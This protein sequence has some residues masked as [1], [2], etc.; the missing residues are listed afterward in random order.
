MSHDLAGLVFGRLTAIDRVV[1][2][3]GYARWRC[4]CS[5]GGSKVARAQTL[6]N[7]RTRSCG[8]LSKEVAAARVTTHGDTS[9]RSTTPEY[10]SYASMKNRCRNPNHHE[11]HRYGGRGIAICERW[12]ESFGAF[13]E[14]MGRKP[15]PSFTIDRIDNDKGYEPGNCRWASRKHQNRNS[16]LSKQVLASD[17]R[18]FTSMAEAAETFGISP[19]AMARA[20]KSGR[21]VD[22][23]RWEVVAN[24][25]GVSP[26]SLVR[27]AG[28]AA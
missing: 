11:F 10:R 24:M 19:S 17:G 7:G 9:N 25:I 18:T 20:C 28:R 27:E 4:S 6:R 15:D 14:D 8:C 23:A 3:D 5:C 16:S 22:G 2:P 21:L 12:L 1:S 13:L 26:S